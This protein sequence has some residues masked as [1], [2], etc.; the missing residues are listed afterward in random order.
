MKCLDCKL[1]KRTFL[2]GI[3]TLIVVSLSYSFLDIKVANFIHTSDFFGTGI[4]TVAAMTSKVFSP[5]VWAILAIIVTLICIYKHIT[6]NPSEKLYIMSLTLI[7]TIIITT[8]IKIILARYRPEMLLFDNR[9]G[10]HFFSLKKAYNSMPSGHTALTFAG[11][12]AIANFFDKKFITVIALVICCFV[13]ASRI[14]ILDHF[15]SDVIL[16]GYIGIFTYLWS[17]AF[18][19]NKRLSK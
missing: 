14:I 19:E 4:S 8:I 10:F 11:L 9:Y 15:I 12:L 13:A 7:M 5:K 3:V 16:A 1:A 2:Y 17:K 6:K 18:V